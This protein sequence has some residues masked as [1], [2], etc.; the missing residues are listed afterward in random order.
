[1]YVCKWIRVLPE[2]PKFS[3]SYIDSESRDTGKRRTGNSAFGL[4]SCNPLRVICFH[5]RYAATPSL[6]CPDSA[7]RTLRRLDDVAE[8]ISFSC[9]VL[10][11][12]HSSKKLNCSKQ[13]R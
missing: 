9:G 8:Y 13:C 2:E 5:S 12:S 7:P 11:D 1:M 10:V 6:G 4:L 3:A